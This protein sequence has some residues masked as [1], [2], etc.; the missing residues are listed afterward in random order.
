MPAKKTK[1]K[2]TREHNENSYLLGAEAEGNTPSTPLLEV[3]QY[4]SL[5][6][7]APVAETV[8]PNANAAL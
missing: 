6:L 5:A 2:N 1:T 8:M 4:N 7:Q 3:F